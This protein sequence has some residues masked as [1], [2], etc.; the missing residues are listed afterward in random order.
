LKKLAF[1]TGHYP[2]FVTHS[3][4]LHK[5]SPVTTNKEVIYFDAI[6]LS[7]NTGASNFLLYTRYTL[8]AVLVPRASIPSQ[9]M[10]FKY[11]PV[12]FTTDT[13]NDIL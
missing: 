3:T 9:I 5:P 13:T 12:R 8:S 7:I 1:F 11:S 4:S 2:S 10:N 6:W